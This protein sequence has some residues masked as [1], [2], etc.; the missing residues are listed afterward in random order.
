MKKLYIYI[1]MLMLLSSNVYAANS[2]STKITKSVTI[3]AVGENPPTTNC[4]LTL[5]R[6]AEPITKVRSYYNNTDYVEYVLPEGSTNTEA[7]AFYSGMKVWK[8]YK[9][10]LYH[11]SSR[12]WS[13]FVSSSNNA[14]LPA[15]ESSYFYVPS[16]ASGSSSLVMNAHSLNTGDPLTDDGYCINVSSGWSTKLTRVYT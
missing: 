13:Y 5:T 6:D 7:L 3:T 16:N 10:V 11:N 1:L 14:D 4:Y 15:C 9:V 12:T 8:G 2:D